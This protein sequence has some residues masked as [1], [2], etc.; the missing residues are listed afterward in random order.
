MT[1]TAKEFF[2][3]KMFPSGEI[4]ENHFDL[5]VF[6][7]SDLKDHI[8]YAVEFAKLHVKAALDAAAENATSFIDIDENTHVE[9]NV[10]SEVDKDSIRNAYPEE[11][12]K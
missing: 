9:G 4:S 8:E 3:L 5:F 7:N 6:T 12:I 2:R 10:W 11:L 1:P